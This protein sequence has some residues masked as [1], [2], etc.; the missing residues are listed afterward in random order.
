[1]LK[2]AF[3]KLLVLNLFLFS[4][5][6]GQATSEPIS[7][8]SSPAQILIEKT[9]SGQ[10]LNFDFLFENNTDSSWRLTNVKLSVYDKSGNLVQQKAAWSGLEATLPSGFTVEPKARKILL[11]PFYAFHSSIDLSRLKYEFFFSEA[12]ENG[13]RFTTGAVVSPIFYQ[14]KTNVILPLRGRVLVYE[15]HDFYAHH[16]RVDLAH[17]IMARLGVT[18]N[19]T[20]YGY[21][22]CS[23]DE[24]GAIY[25]NKGE[26]NED[27]LGFGTPIVA[28]ADGVVKE[29]R[30]TVEDNILG[31]KM[32]DFRLVF[33]DIKAFYG[34]YVIIDHQNGEFSLLLHLKKGSVAVKPGDKIKAGQTVGQM[35]ISGDSDYVHLHYQL[36]NAVEINN[37]TLPVYFRNFRWRRGKSFET[38]KSGSLETGDF[39]ESLIN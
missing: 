2:K 10:E 36:Q 3:G 20:R 7:V 39:V 9:K 12:K 1:M 4:V 28:P 19:P 5:S 30:N 29:I 23:A 16:R 8:R 18:T 32:F 26:T 24:N 34:N 37:E 13:A 11:N 35:G 14:P 38:V 31:G 17:P 6:F 33:Q 27:W 15:G 25:R 21:D 22:F